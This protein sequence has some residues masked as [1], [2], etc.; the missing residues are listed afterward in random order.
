MTSLHTTRVRRRRLGA[1]AAAAGLLATL[2]T[3]TTAA[4]TPDPGDAPAERGSVTKSEQ[5]EARAAITGGD[6]PGVDEIVHSSNIKHLTNVPKGALQ[7]LNTDLAFQGKYA[8]VGNYDGFVIYDIS[9]PKKPKTV[10]QVLCPA[11]RTTSPSP[12]TCCSSRRTPR[13]ATT[14]APAP[15]SPPRRSPPGRA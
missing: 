11:R 2:L 7:G 13:A 10:S 1:V 4:A 9:K 15:P 5:A 8:F 6:I 14:P 3:A 12:G